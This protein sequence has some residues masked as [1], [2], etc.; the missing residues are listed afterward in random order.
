MTSFADRTI[1]ALRVNHDRLRELVSGLTDE[2]LVLPS[3]ASEWQ[4]AQLLSHLGSGAEIALAALRAT[5]AEQGPPGSDFNQGV[6]DRWNAMS[7]RAQ[8]EG[9]LEADSRLVAAYEDLDPETR[10]TLTVQLGFLPFPL[11]VAAVLGMRLNEA[12]LHHWD[13]A[14]AFDPGA[15]LAADAAELIAEHF[16]D[17]IGFLLGFTAKADVIPGRA[18]IALAGT[19][20]ALL[21]DDSVSL[22]T[23]I[24][25]ATGAFNGPIES[26]VRLLAGRLRPEHTPDDV[27]VTG[28][29]TLDDLRR[30]FPG[31]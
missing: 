29:V 22:T 24:E 17:D 14:V 19:K 18:A 6:W 11:P 3:G 20:Y 28:D 9:C 27:T 7:A 8:A 12:V 2:Q 15:T 25:D 10:Q 1:A 5:L 26:A 4:V 23:T 21:V 30:V 16:A 31:Y 13:V